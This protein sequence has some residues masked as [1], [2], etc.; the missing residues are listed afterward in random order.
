[1]ISAQLVGLPLKLKTPSIG[2]VAITYKGE[3]PVY[4]HIELALFKTCASKLIVKSGSFSPI[5]N[6]RNDADTNVFTV[7]MDEL[8]EE[9]T[10]QIL[11]ESV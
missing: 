1:M 10:G 7:V 5:D 2:P 11:Y 4:Q 8:T 9:L 6:E 3:L